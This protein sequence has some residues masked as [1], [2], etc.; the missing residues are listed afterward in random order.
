MQPLEH[1]TSW[2]IE[3][4]FVQ[5]VT[6]IH[7]CSS[8]FYM[9]HIY[10]I[11]WLSDFEYH[12]C[13]QVYNVVVHSVHISS[14]HLLQLMRM[15]RKQ[16]L[17]ELSILIELGVTMRWCIRW[18]ISEDHQEIRCYLTTSKLLLTY[19]IQSWL[20]LVSHQAF[21]W[22]PPIKLGSIKLFFVNGHFGM[23]SVPDPSL[24]PGSAVEVIE[25][26]PSFRLCV[27]V[28]VA[29]EMLITDFVLF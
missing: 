6:D 1:E 22:F 21:L 19:I 9:E 16:L 29:T 5:S 25:S 18:V 17:N 10:F 24:P 12:T 8:R 2:S 15:M 7:V 23:E 3:W 13:F 14:Y 28:S 20:E 26:E 27:C 11:T 4:Y